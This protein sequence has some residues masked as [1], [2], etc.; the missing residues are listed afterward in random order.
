LFEVVKAMPPSA[1]V[2]A[3]ARLANELREV[4]AEEAFQILAGKEHADSQAMTKQQK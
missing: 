3:I 4:K 1:S 2:R